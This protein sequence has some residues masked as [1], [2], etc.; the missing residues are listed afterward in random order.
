MVIG[1]YLAPYIQS[2]VQSNKPL[3]YREVEYSL[4]QRTVERKNLNRRNLQN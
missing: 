4:S 2:I 3:L 1:L